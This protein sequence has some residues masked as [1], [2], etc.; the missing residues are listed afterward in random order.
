MF[1]LARPSTVSYIVALA[2]KES[3]AIGFL[4]R[5]R[6]EQYVQNGQVA[7][8]HENGNLCGFLVWGNGF[9]ILRIYQA[10]IQYDARGMAHGAQMV[11]RLERAATARGYS[12]IQLRCA[13]DL[14]A[15]SFWRALDY[16][17]V[18]TINGG[19]TR[20][21]TLNVWSKSL[22]EPLQ[23]C[24]LLGYPGERSARYT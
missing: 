20:R 19:A 15:N 7:I 6:L 22:E 11:G 16:D 4:P 13:N 14:P 2:R 18:S 10:C 21:R 12:A 1:D 24:L 3:E 23:P 5:P 9:P 17:L 8:A